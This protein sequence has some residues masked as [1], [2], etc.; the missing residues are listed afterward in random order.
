ML[1]W[2]TAVNNVFVHIESKN[3]EIY[4]T[5]GCKYTVL[6]DVDIEKRAFIGTSRHMMRC[7]KN[8]AFQ[9]EKV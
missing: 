7:L 8:N 5:F 2:K 1:F 6:W 9:G 4:S 3:D